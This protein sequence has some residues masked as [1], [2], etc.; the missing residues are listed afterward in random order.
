[1]GA[2]PGARRARRPATTVGGKAGAGPTTGDAPGAAPVTVPVPPGAEVRGLT[3][4]A[5]AFAGGFVAGGVAGGAERLRSALALRH[6]SAARGLAAPGAACGWRGAGGR[7]VDRGGPRRATAGGGAALAGV[8]HEGIIPV[9]RSG[10][11]WC[12]R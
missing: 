10:G 2:G 4:A 3:G 6:R 1:A 12:G 11:S 7:R 9:R 5:G 8:A